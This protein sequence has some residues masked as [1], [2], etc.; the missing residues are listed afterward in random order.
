M[1]GKFITC[2]PQVIERNLRNSENSKLQCSV[3]RFYNPTTQLCKVNYSLASHNRED[4][5]ICGDR[6]KKYLAKDTRNLQK[7]VKYLYYSNNLTAFGISMIPALF[8][9]S[10]VYFVSVFAFYC[11]NVYSKKSL[12][13]Y[14]KYIKDNDN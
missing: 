13:C 14:Q 5:T 10:R 2:P 1:Q 7:S 8:V 6:G 4:E 11:S 12:E 9:D 3:C